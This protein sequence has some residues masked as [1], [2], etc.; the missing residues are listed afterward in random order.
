MCV[1]GTCFSSRLLPSISS[2]WP[3]WRSVAL[4][5]RHWETKPESSLFLL[6]CKRWSFS[7]WTNI[8]CDPVIFCFWVCVFISCVCMREKERRNGSPRPSVCLMSLF[9][10]LI[11]THWPSRKYSHMTESHRHISWF[12]WML[13]WQRQR[14]ITC[15]CVHSYSINNPKHIPLFLVSP[16][17]NRGHRV[18]QFFFHWYIYVQI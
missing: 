10:S 5:E 18:T 11:R 16:L 3:L 6:F 17:L 15:L 14:I 13:V 7:E 2:P 9:E 1:V 4:A 12:M 8:A